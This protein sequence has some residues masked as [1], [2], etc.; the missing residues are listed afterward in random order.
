MHSLESN[1]DSADF[2]PSA[3]PALSGH[4]GSDDSTF[5]S[6]SLCR[7]LLRFAAHCARAVR[8]AGASTDPVWY[9]PLGARA[10]ASRLVGHVSRQR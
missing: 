6:I 10:P 7:A 3:T 1:I 8:T 4:R 5:C 9:T 2:C